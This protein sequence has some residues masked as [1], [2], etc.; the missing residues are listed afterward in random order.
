MF[1]KNET[2]EEFIKISAHSNLIEDGI[3]FYRGSNNRHL[4]NTQ[5]IQNNK[6]FKLCEFYR[7]LRNQCGVK[8]LKLLIR[9]TERGCPP[10]IKKIEIWGYPS[11][12]YTKEKKNDIWNM[13]NGIEDGVHI[14]LKAKAPIPKAP[15]QKK[16]S[17]DADIIIPEEFLDTITYEIMSIPMVLPSG[18]I[19]DKTTLEKHN[20]LEECWGRSPTDPFTFVPFTTSRR[21]VLNAHLKSQIDRF[22]L[23]NSDKPVFQTIPRTVGS[24]KRTRNMD[25]FS[26]TVKRFKTTE[27]SIKPT[28]TITSNILSAYTVFSLSSSTLSTTTQSSEPSLISTVP[29]QSSIEIEKAVQSALQNITRFSKLANPAAVEIKNNSCYQC[30]TIDECLLYAIKLCSHLI[31]RKCLLTVNQ[32]D[33]DVVNDSTSRS[34]Q[35]ARM[36][37]QCKCGTNFNKNDVSRFYN[38]EM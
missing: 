37:R 20:R 6:D 33:T 7:T 23:A 30:G 18:K 10:V 1:V 21:P 4:D 29:S 34:N 3:I 38:K 16:I 8:T 9:S 24:I 2:D 31:C 15:N 28:E 27:T 5:M 35:A 22:L 14:E 26:T 11:K 13:W 25:E 19:V 12:S 36:K 17:L 32:T